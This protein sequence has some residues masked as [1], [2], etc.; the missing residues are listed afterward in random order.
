MV[1]NENKDNY[2]F[3]SVIEPHGSFDPKLESVQDPHS[4]VTNISLLQQD[5]KYTAV[6]VSFK[7]GKKYTLLFANK[8]QDAKA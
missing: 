5:E 4:K 1:R 3:V 7:N 2:T 8:P 6:S